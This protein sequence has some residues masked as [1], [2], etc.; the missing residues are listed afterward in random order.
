[1]KYGYGDTG[2]WIDGGQRTVEELNREIID[3]AGWE[4]W[5]PKKDDRNYLKSG[6]TEWLS[7]IADKAVEWL[8]ENCTEEGYSFVLDE[9]CLV[10]YGPEEEEEEEE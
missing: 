10:L 7:E 9:G 5:K 1:M 6:D 4:G 2:C 8:D 3:M